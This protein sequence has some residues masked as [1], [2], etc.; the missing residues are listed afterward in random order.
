MPQDYHH[1][2]KKQGGKRR[3]K[4]MLK[5][6]VDEHGNVVE[7]LADKRGSTSAM[8][9]HVTKASQ[10]IADFDQAWAQ[11]SASNSRE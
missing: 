8:E 11:A 3:A 1:E 2:S 7:R 9:Y 10:A 6:Y 4:P 5:R